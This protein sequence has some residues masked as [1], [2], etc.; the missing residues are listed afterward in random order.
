MMVVEMGRMMMEVEEMLWLVLGRVLLVCRFLL[1]SRRECR[2]ILWEEMGRCRF[3]Y[4]C[5]YFYLSKIEGAI[6]K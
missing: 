4:I 2:L 5:I 1:C 6:I 3:P